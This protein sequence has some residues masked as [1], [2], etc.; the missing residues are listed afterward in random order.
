MIKRYLAKLLD[1]LAPRE[2]LVLL[3]L[4]VIV[5]IATGLAAV[6]FIRLIGFIQVT[7]YGGAENIFSG[8]RPLLDNPDTGHRWTSCRA[9]HRQICHGGQRPRGP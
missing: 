3:V 1:H 2:G 6:F 5:G 8:L 7:A 9:H 4:A